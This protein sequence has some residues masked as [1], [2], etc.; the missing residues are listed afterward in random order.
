M[1]MMGK[2]L[3]SLMC[4]EVLKIKIN[5]PTGKWAKGKKSS[6]KKEMLMALIMQKASQPT[7]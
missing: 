5:N 2:V 6:W 3:P 7:S 4:K 1:Y